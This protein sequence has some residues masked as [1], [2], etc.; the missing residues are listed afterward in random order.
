[1]PELLRTGCQLALRLPSAVRWANGKGKVRPLGRWLAMP[2]KTVTFHLQFSTGHR[3]ESGWRRISWATAG[4]ETASLRVSFAAAAPV[5]SGCQEEGPGRG[6]GGSL[7]NGDRARAR[8]AVYGPKVPP[9]PLSLGIAG[10]RPMKKVNTA[11]G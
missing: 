11:D 2:G 6:P 3:C 8:R 7:D 1:M 10:H 5:V 9:E 4:T